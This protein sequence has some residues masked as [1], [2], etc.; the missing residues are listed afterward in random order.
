[1]FD[2]TEIFKLNLHRIAN[3]G[4]CSGELTE[5][6][7]I[8]ISDI[9]NRADTSTVLLGMMD[10][11]I[12][13]LADIPDEQYVTLIRIKKVFDVVI[14]AH[15]KRLYSS[16]I[17]GSVPLRKEGSLYIPPTDTELLTLLEER[18]NSQ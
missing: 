18:G 11:L 4:V 6:I 3:R 12:I 14:K 2:L 16:V 17:S 13:S 5:T 7:A 10:D 15:E 8:L 1:M 9:I